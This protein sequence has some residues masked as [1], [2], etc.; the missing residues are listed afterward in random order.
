LIAGV[1]MFPLYEG[2]DFMFGDPRT[3]PIHGCVTSS[4]D[5][6]FDAPC[7]ACEDSMS[8]SPHVEEDDP[9]VAYR[10]GNPVRESFFAE[11]DIPF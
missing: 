11:D 9:I 6:L 7:G 8:D 4:G 10:M 2:D 5:G 1:K 3:C